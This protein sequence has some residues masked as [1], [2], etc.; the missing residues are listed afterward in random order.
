MCWQAAVAAFWKE[1]KDQMKEAQERMVE[2]AQHIKHSFDKDPGAEERDTEGNGGSEAAIQGSEIPMEA[3]EWQQQDN[4]LA[5]PRA[6]TNHEEDFFPRTSSAGASS[7]VALELLDN[8]GAYDCSEQTRRTEPVL[9]GRSRRR[10]V[11]TPRS[12]LRRSEAEVVISL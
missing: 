12:P 6:D 4:P 2:A 5:S 3:L 11:G 1:N 7:R 8:D 9:E 10:T